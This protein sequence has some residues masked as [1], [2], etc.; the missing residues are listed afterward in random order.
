M[1]NLHPLAEPYS[2]KIR[3]RV[4]GLLVQD[5]KLL[6][7]RHTAAFGEG[8]FW[9]PPGGGVEYGE[10]MKECL[11]REFLEET[12]LQV[13]VGRFLYLNEFLRPPLHAIEFFFEVKLLAGELVLV[14]DP[15]HSSQEQLLKEVKFM[16]VKDIIQLRRDEVHAMMHALV[17]L[18]D[19]FIPRHHFL[20]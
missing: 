2:A 13:A 7:A 15:E 20:D 10:R 16:G 19:L 6:L 18:D 1:E 3:V 11:E 12:G 9:S 14:S 5:N 8:V 17:N 4:C